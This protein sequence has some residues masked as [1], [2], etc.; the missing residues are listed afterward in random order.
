[1]DMSISTGTA[2]AILGRR[3]SVCRHGCWM[4]TKITFMRYG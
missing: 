4:R 2:R 3:A 1:M